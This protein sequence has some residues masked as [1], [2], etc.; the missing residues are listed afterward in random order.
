MKMRETINS[1]L[2]FQRDCCDPNWR[3]SLFQAFPTLDKDKGG[4]AP[5]PK[6]K[7]YLQNAMRKIYSEVEPEIDK[8]AAA[9]NEYWQENEAKVNRAFSEIFG[10]D[11]K[12]LL[13]D[14]VAEASLNTICPRYLNETRFTFF[15]RNTPDRFMDTALHEMIHFAWFYIWHNIFHDDKREYESPHLKWLLSETVV[16]TFANNSML[17]KLFSE[18]GRKRSAYDCFYT[19]LAEGAPILEILTDL[20]KTRNLADFMKSAYD[21]YK[22]HETEIRN[23]SETSY[24]REK[25]ISKTL[26]NEGR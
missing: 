10:L 16:D 2:D 7:L 11:F 12:N 15:Y 24:A 14:M 26:G 20:Y 4:N 17:G 19:M 5:W 1:V 18:Q 22:E 25:T 3:A 6:R 21:Y 8:K 13:N 23:Q 9:L